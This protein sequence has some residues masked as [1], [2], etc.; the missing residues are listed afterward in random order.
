[1]DTC[2][3]SFFRPSALSCAVAGF[4]RSHVV[5]ALPYRLALFPVSKRGS[6]VR[7]YVE[8]FELFI[9]D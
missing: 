9:D 2:P 4:Y 6:S 8:D 3:V 5:L 7:V 1:M